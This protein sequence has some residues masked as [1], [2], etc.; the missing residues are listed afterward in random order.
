MKKLMRILTRAWW[1]SLDYFFNNFF[2]ESIILELYIT[3]KKFHRQGVLDRVELPTVS[4]DP[5]A[6]A[7]ARP[8]TRSGAFSGARAGSCA[9]ANAA[10]RSN[11]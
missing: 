6:D 11:G 1:R 2:A 5:C 8:D 3:K 4:I 7:D 9:D 10:A